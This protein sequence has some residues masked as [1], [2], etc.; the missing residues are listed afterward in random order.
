[1]V[2]AHEGPVTANWIF[3]A[4]IIN[5]RDMVYYKINSCISWRVK[6]S[7]IIN[8]CTYKMFINVPYVF[9]FRMLRPTLPTANPVSEG[10]YIKLGHGHLLL[11][12]S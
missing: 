5:I 3:W 1:M 6:L 4:L 8:I 11:D 7:D 10:Q 2:C 9:S 12:P